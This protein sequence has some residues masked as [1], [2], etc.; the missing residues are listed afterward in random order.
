MRTET[1]RGVGHRK[2]HLPALASL[3]SIEGV[4]RW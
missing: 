1:E 4:L 3:R 2:L